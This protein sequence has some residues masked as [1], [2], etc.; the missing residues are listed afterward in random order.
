VREL[1]VIIHHKEIY[2]QMQN[3]LFGV[4]HRQC[5]GDV[6][7]V[8]YCTSL[9]GESH[10]HAMLIMYTCFTTCLCNMLSS[11]GHEMAENATDST[12]GMSARSDEI[13]GLSTS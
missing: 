2:T 1:Q 3:S 11:Q 8:L 12:S 4:S 13:T 7:G 6:N 10:H 9:F 5:H